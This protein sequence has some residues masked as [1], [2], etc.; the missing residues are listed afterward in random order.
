MS[1][2]LSVIDYS[3]TCTLFSTIGY[4]R[5]VLLGDL[6]VYLIVYLVAYLVSSVRCFKSGGAED[7]LNKLLLCTLKS[8]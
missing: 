7:L 1:L 4:L 2:F 5:L 8:S 3:I 6:L